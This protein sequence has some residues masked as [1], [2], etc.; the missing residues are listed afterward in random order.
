MMADLS[1]DIN[2]LKI[3]NKLMDEKNLD[4][5]LGSRFLKGS[6][7]KDYPFQKL[8]LNRVFNFFVSLIFWN[9]YNDYTNA[10]KIYKK[11]VLKTMMPFVSESFNIF[12]EIPLKIISRNYSYQII[13]IN[14]IGRKKGEAKFR[15]KELRS[16]YLFTLLYCFF[17]RILLNIRK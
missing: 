2:D 16:K 12:L 9:R 17:E 6:E 7:V 4:A 8:L 13:K 10:F 15:I 11:E 1:D 5:V 14:W 3:Y